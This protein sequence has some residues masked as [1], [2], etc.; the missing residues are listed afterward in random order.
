MQLEP[1]GLGYLFQRSCADFFVPVLQLRQVFSRQ[2]SVIRQ[3]GLRP[4]A[5]RPQDA[6]TPSDSHANVR[7]HGSSMAVFCGLLVS[8][9]LQV[10]EFSTE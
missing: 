3:H 5:L 10:I 4:P 9:G 6:N 7:C 2:F 1:E 8:Y